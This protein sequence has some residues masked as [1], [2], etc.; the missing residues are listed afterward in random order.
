MSDIVI[1]FD[2]RLGARWRRAFLVGALLLAVAP[3]LGS[4]SIT[5]ST[6]YPAPSGVYTNMITTSDTR[7][8]RDGG[9]VGIG[10][11]SSALAG[12]L[13]VRNGRACISG[14]N[15][16]ACPNNRMTSG[17]L[18]IG[19][20]T[21]NFGGGT[22]WNANTAGLLMEA[23]IRTEIAVHDSGTRIASLMQYEGDGTNRITVGRDMAWGPISSVVLNG[24]VGIKGQVPAVALDVPQNNAMRVGNAYLSSGGNYMHLANNEY[25]NGGSWQPMGGSGVLLQ[26]SGQKAYLYSHNGAGS[27]TNMFQFHEN[28]VMIPIGGASCTATQY[29]TLGVTTCP[30]GRYAAVVGGIMTKYSIMPVYRDVSGNSA[31]G[32]ML[33]CTCPAGG[34]PGL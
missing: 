30:A 23:A 15:P 26:F 8:A 16:Y 34:C 10:T 9:S 24:N 27:H 28:G 3:E 11:G 29:N 25:Y 17:S 14:V 5:L 31:W 33:C 32:M 1:R 21:N 22:N 2:L 18:T 7:L 12:K 4:E 13:D 19:D 6:Y 20:T